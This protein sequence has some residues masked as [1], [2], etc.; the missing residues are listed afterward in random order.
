MRKKTKYTA[1]ETLPAEAITVSQFARKY[2]FSSP[3]YVHLKFTRY[4]FGY[5]S[6]IG[7]DLKAEYPGYDLVDFRGNC[8][9]IVKDEEKIKNSMR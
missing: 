2:K 7:T 5:K 6:G 3:S 9:V 1:V 4:K 8:Y